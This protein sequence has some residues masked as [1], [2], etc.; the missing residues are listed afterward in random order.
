MEGRLHIH[1]KMEKYVCVCVCV[2]TH[3][4]W[5]SSGKEPTCQCRRC[6]RH[7]F[8]SW[9]RKTPWRMAWQPTSVSLPGESHVQR[10]LMGYSP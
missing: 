9:V 4:P 10:R 8:N 7:G 6:K 2:H 1:L 5:A 3:K